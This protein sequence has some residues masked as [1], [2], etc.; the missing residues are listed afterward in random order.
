MVDENNNYWFVEIQPQAN[1]MIHYGCR[2]TAL[3]E[4]YKACA[5]CRRIG[6]YATRL[7]Y[8]GRKIAPQ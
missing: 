1:R 6:G 8:Q 4:Y 7:L 2:S 5:S 3:P